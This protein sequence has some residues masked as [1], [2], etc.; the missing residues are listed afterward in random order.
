M[1]YKFVALI[2]IDGFLADLHTEWLRR[3]NEK[4]NDQLTVRDI[5]D[6]NIHKFALPECGTSMYDFIEDPSIYDDVEP[7]MGSLGFVNALYGHPSIRTVYVT[8]S[9]VGTMGRKYKWLKDNG[10]PVTPKGY[11]ETADKSLIRG[12]VLVDDYQENLKTFTGNKILFDSYWNRSVL[13]GDYFRAYD[14]NDVM[15]IISEM[16]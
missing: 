6:W 12:D 8:S 7:L 14:Y 1:I 15:K 2:D 5:T 4:Y 3:Y 11:I 13:G 9:T 10:F 16:L